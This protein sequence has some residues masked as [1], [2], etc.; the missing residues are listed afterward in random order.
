MKLRDLV[1]EGQ[2]LMRNNRAT[3]DYEIYVAT[4]CDYE[5]AARLLVGMP[6]QID[7]EGRFAKP[8][9]E[10]R[11]ERSDSPRSDPTQNI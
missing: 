11:P 9:P 3:A 7:L 8:G 2:Q 1:R 10:D 6:G 4:S 5:P